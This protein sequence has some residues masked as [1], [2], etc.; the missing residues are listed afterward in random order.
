MCTATPDTLE[1]PVV[2][3]AASTP[4][5]PPVR[6]REEGGPYGDRLAGRGTLLVGTFGPISSKFTRRATSRASDGSRS[7]CAGAAALETGSEEERGLS[8][9]ARVRQCDCVHAR[10]GVDRRLV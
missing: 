9:V 3:A 1:S 4:A 5:P 10:D 8:V 6:R 7:A 2:S